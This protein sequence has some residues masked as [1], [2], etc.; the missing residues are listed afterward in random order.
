MFTKNG[1]DKDVKRTLEMLDVRRKLINDTPAKELP[2]TYAVNELANAL[3]PG[4]TKATIKE[5]RPCS[6]NS[7]V[8][9]LSSKKFPYFP[10]K[11]CCGYFCG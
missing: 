8:I 7:K 2:K 9:T 11:K 5:I 1:V 4:F 3:H 10:K 6:K